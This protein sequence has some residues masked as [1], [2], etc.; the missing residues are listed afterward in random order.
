[1]QLVRFLRKNEIYNPQE[2]AGFAPEVAARLVNAGVAEYVAPGTEAAGVAK[3]GGET[4]EMGSV[5]NFKMPG[6]KK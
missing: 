5:S 2:V 6:K 1:M 3:Q 4:E